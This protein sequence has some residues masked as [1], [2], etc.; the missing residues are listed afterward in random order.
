MGVYDWIIGITNADADG[1]RL[2]RIKGSIEQV[3]AAIME[4]VEEDKCED[5]GAFEYGTE[6][7]SDIEEVI[8]ETELYAYN[9]FSTYHIDYMAKRLD[10]IQFR[11]M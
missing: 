5:C 6:D 11:E 1:I 4:F 7:V 3:K 10:A 2:V 9:V 8:K